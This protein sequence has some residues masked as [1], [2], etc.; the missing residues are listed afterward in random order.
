MHSL[1]KVLMI[2]E[3]LP[4]PFDRRVWMEATSLKE[5]GYQVFVICPTG[6][7]YEQEFEEID[8]IQIYRHPLP[9]EASSAK[10]YLWEYFSALTWE[11]RLARRIWKEQDGFN[12]VHICNP[13][14]LLFLVGAWFKLFKGARVI[15]DQH[16]LNPELYEAKFG[17]RGLFYHALLLA[18]RLTFACADVVISTN[19]SY[20][21]IALTR[22]KKQE[23]QVFV[24]RSGPDLEKFTL[25][26]ANK[27]Y[28]RGK[29]YLV[30]YVGV[31][32][33]QEGID[34]LLRSI[35]YIVHEQNR[36]D[37]HFMLIGGGPAVEAMKALAHELEVSDYVEFTGRVP[38]RELI[39]RLSSCDLCVNPD[40]KT[41]FNDVSTMNKIVEYMALGK[42]IVQ[43]D[44]LEGRRSAGAASF[45]AKANDETDFAQKIAHLLDSPD[46]RLQ[47]GI[48][49]MTRMRDELEWRHQVPKL[50]EAYA[51]ALPVNQ[52][53]QSAPRIG[54]SAGKHL[55]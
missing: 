28:F 23:D 39:E 24:V 19:E 33:E 45:Y 11:F 55:H 43:F 27:K 25:L 32:G 30:G 2:V 52:R 53:L 6:K 54:A 7:G 20:R 44:V 31:M 15:F 3:N 13:P 36:K 26:P 14:D 18:E 8:D 51:Q 1:G 41:P 38:D 4:V 12:I 47:M 22:G 35:R 34:Y 50:L 37:I 48:F 49:G 5:A 17:R 40:P 9:P 42:A 10:G 16:D 21:H 46:R 29:P